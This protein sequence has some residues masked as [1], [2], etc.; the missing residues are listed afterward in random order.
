MHYFSFL[1]LLSSL[2]HFYSKKLTISLLLSIALFNLYGYFSSF[3]LLHENSE[4]QTLV[5][6]FT[7]IGV[8][9]L[10]Y[11]T[12][13]STTEFIFISI[14]AS[15]SLEIVLSTHVSTMLFY[16]ELACLAAIG[17][18]FCSK[19]TNVLEVG[20][21]YAAIHFSGGLLISA[22]T[23]PFLGYGLYLIPL[24]NFQQNLLLLGIIINIGCFPFSAWVAESY[25][26]ANPKATVALQL[27]TSKA[28][29]FILHTLFSGTNCLLYIGLLTLIY[30][31]VFCL[32][33]NNLRKFL[34]YN[35]V[36]QNGFLVACIGAGADVVPYMFASAAYQTLLT[37]IGANL[38]KIET[39]FKKFENYN[40]RNTTLIITSLISIA[41][42]G[43]LPLSNTFST[44]LLLLHSIN[45]P[46][47]E[48]ILTA[49]SFLLLF[50]CG[51]R[52]IYNLYLWPSPSSKAVDIFPSK[53]EKYTCLALSV[54]CLI[55]LSKVTFSLYLYMEYMVAFL[56]T[57]L[58]FAA[59]KKLLR[60]TPRNL[61]DSDW[62]Y[63][64]LL[65]NSIITINNFFTF[66]RRRVISTIYNKVP[67]LERS[68]HLFQVENIQHTI[69]FS[70]IMLAFVLLIN[71][72]V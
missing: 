19:Q 14:Y 41:S 44:K 47:L 29:L 59:L 40:L 46:L 4:I 70:I 50:C 69:L 32:L 27:F 68:L 49:G 24:S 2:S 12:S 25:S 21:R 67:S 58:I 18:I 51:L 54:F 23:L 35:N 8:I 16:T 60:P 28:L 20:L 62:F 64:G 55:P 10:I 33:E 57:I 5:T 13:L 43:S 30:G 31:A 65:L 9:V 38:S 45:N 72:Y 7:T 56:L 11:A 53:D 39:T 71:L 36:G 6:L 52:F 63:R 37:V 22:A 48:N 42:M 15:S 61:I 17:V 34:L 66:T 26:S 1:F 3:S